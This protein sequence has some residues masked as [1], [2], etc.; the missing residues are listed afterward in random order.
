MPF[1]ISLNAQQQSKERLDYWY[2]N[3]PQVTVVAPDVG[4][5]TGGNEIVLR[6]ENFK[7]FRPALG[8]I[9]ISNSTYC[10]F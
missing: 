10:A 9:D 2:Y 3:E 7:P 6:G 4:P 8:E 1:S 5:E